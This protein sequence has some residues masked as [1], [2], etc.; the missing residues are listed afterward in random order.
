MQ[1]ECSPGHKG[2]EK[3]KDNNITN[4]KGALELRDHD[5]VL[6]DRIH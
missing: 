6:G 1:L 5:A 3:D 4:N 2:L